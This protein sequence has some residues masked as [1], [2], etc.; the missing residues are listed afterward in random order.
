MDFTTENKYQH[1]GRQPRRGETAHQ[2]TVPRGLGHSLGTDQG[3]GGL[4]RQHPRDW[5]GWPGKGQGPLT[6]IPAPVPEQ[7][8]Q[9]PLVWTSAQWSPKA[10]VLLDLCSFEGM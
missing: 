6:G 10:H 7:E 5:G 9:A 4:V 8:G 3:G 2:E 1:V